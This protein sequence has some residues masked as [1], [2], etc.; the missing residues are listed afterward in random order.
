M[1]ATPSTIL[2]QARASG[3]TLFRKGDGLHVTPTP[4]PGLVAALRQFKPGILELLDAEARLAPDERAWLPVAAQ[5]LAGEWDSG[6]RSE[7]ESVL[8]GVR[9]IAHPLCQQA[10]ARLETLLGR[11]RKES[12]P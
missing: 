3:F 11:T 7:I 9:G 12:R 10:R 2:A 6:T 4:P 8:I 5:I 1:T